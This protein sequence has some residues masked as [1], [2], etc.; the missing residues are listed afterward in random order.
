MIKKVVLILAIA[1]SAI[2]S[3]QKNKAGSKVNKENLAQAE[4]RDSKIGIGAPVASFDKEIYDFGT[5]TEGKLVETTF[6]ITN[7]GK[8][9]LIIT[10][11]KATCG[12]TVPIWPKGPIAPGKADNVKVSFNTNGRKNKQ[13]KTVSLYTNT[14]KGIETLKITGMVSPKEK[15]Q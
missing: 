5:V 11:A 9:D 14:E 3:C 7:K 10:D 8:S 6:V 1:I 12:C 15:K 13:T 4:K 2:L